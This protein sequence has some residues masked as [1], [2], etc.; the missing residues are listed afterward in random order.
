MVNPPEYDLRSLGTE[1]RKTFGTNG[2]VRN[3]GM[4]TGS[5][6]RL[7]QIYIFVNSTLGQRK[8][9]DMRDGLG[10]DV[11]RKFNDAT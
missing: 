5:A 4:D 11:R 1:T 10:V 6:V 8:T 9:W 3:V 7:I 2:G